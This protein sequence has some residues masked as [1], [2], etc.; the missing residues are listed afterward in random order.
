[1]WNRY[2]V[3][4]NISCLVNQLGA[5]RVPT[6]EEDFLLACTGLLFFSIL[7]IKKVGGLVFNNLVFIIYVAKLQNSPS[8]M[9]NLSF[10]NIIY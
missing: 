5:P 6:E 9:N 2:Q 8:S 7:S 3:E 4:H 1:M 10:L